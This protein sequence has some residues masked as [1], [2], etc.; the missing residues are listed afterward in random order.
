MAS[1]PLVLLLIFEFGSDLEFEQFPQLEEHTH[2]PHFQGFRARPKP[3]RYLKP[4]LRPLRGVCREWKGLIEQT[5]TSWVSALLR[6][7]LKD[8]ELPSKTFEGTQDDL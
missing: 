4:F 2:G 7:S 5:S 1:P 3:Q 6:V 8:A